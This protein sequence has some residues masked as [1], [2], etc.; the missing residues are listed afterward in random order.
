[1]LYSIS[2]QLQHIPL[3]YLLLFYYFL[4]IFHMS[5]PYFFDYTV[6]FLREWPSFGM[7]EFPLL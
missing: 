6:T 7:F 2:N 3:W 4:L 5:I 1:M